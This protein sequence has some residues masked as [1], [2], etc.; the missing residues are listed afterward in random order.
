M[1]LLYNIGWNVFR[2]GSI[3]IFV[4]YIFGMD[5]GFLGGETG[6]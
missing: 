2:F 3:V 4:C 6:V 1:A 5:C